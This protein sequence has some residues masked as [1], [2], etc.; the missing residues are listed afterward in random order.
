MTLAS[1]PL[2][3]I[4]GLK[5]GEVEKS[6]VADFSLDGVVGGPCAPVPKG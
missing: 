4:K 1:H 2:E 6:K 5:V 3:A